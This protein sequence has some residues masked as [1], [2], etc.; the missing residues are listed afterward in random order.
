MPAPWGDSRS[1]R[2]EG[3]GRATAAWRGLE[4]DEIQPLS[5]LYVLVGPEVRVDVELQEVG[6]RVITPHDGASLSDTS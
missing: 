2:C 3:G 1:G 6:R 5:E 4:L